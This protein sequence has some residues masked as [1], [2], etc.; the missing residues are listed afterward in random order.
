MRSRF[1]SVINLGFL[2]G[3][4][5]VTSVTLPDSSASN[6]SD[7]LVEKS[8][9]KPVETPATKADVKTPQNTKTLPRLELAPLPQPSAL[10]QVQL[11]AVS[12]LAD[13]VEI[14]P[15][16]P[17]PESVSPPVVEPM[18]QPGPQP[19]SK[20]GLQP[21]KAAELAVLP[22]PIR[23]P[24]SVPSISPMAAAATTPAPNPSPSPSLSPSASPSARPVPVEATPRLTARLSSLLNAT[25]AQSNLAN[26]ANLANPDQGIIVEVST[27]SHQSLAKPVTPAAAD[28]AVARRTIEQAEDAP[29][30][31]FLWPTNSSSH[32]QI[33]HIL[34]QCLGMI[35]GHI[36]RKGE[37]AVARGQ[38]VMQ[39]N[40]AIHSPLL[41]SFNQPVTPQ[42]ARLVTSL[43]NHSGDGDFIRIFRKNTDINVL[44]GF[45]KMTQNKGHMGQQHLQGQ[46]TAEYFL[47]H[48]GLF[49]EQVT[50]NGSPLDGRVQLFKGQCS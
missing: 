46:I 21:V 28:I 26:P 33:Y 8:V 40:R 49:L 43:R 44:A 13:A 5:V 2:L 1:S 39:F 4:A 30:L 7:K 18:P 48:D 24:V 12:S 38:G 35:V 32:R 50:H 34:T 10:L 22:P 17:M 29:S 19:I 25:Q 20:L 14:E 27:E 31:E 23:S 16:A 45:R 6:S 41:R 15:V 11:M 36:D 9:K 42:E 3:L 47:A 37:V